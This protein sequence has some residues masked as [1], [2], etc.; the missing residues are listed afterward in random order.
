MALAFGLGLGALGWW[1][2]QEE[3]PEGGPAALAAK[4]EAQPPAAAPASRVEAR[5][6]GGSVLPESVAMATQADAASRGGGAAAVGANAGAV[7]AVPAVSAAVQAIDDEFGLP[8]TGLPKQRPPFM[9]ANE[10][11]LI[12]NA[13]RQGSQTDEE[14]AQWINNLR[15][16]RLIKRWQALPLSAE[17]PSPRGRAAQ[18]LL[19]E[20]RPRLAA[21]G[22]D[23][24]ALRGHLPDILRDAIANPLE[25]QQMAQALA[26]AINDAQGARPN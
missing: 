17:Q 14:A 12:G 4:A 24:P 8:V 2:T 21:N 3:P 7:P 25:R 19:Q 6:V 13:L 10:W 16:Q 26:E 23:T 1:L 9:N 15:Y 11:D 22:L 18:L 20:V 5:A